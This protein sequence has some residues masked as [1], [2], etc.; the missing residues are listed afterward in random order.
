MKLLSRVAIVIAVVIVVLLS[1]VFFDHFTTE[2]FIL[3]RGREN[4]GVGKDSLY[5]QVKQ[6]ADR[7]AVVYEFIRYVNDGLED[8]PDFASMPIEEYT[9]E[10]PI[11]IFPVA[12]ETWESTNI[13]PSV[14][15]A[16]GAWES[17]WGKE[18]W[19]FNF[20]GHTSDCNSA[21]TDPILEY[22]KNG[23]TYVVGFCSHENHKDTQEHQKQY[24]KVQSSGVLYHFPV[25]YVDG[26]EA[27]IKFLSKS[28]YRPAGLITAADVVEDESSRGLSRL[29]FAQL[30]SISESGYN[31]TEGYSENVESAAIRPNAEDDFKW[32]DPGEA[33]WNEMI[34]L[35]Q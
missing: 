19:G 24:L 4:Q 23:R 29:A 6:A 10:F 14:T 20:Y 7:E 17:G 26:I 2:D 18:P 31:R 1:L 16:Q 34:R 5:E 15:L 21:I 30:K 11:Y 3:Q 22:E 13:L 8:M 12:K 25:T 32:Y 35:Y 33:K 9:S 28:H 27:R